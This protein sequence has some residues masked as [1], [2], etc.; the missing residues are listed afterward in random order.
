[1]CI[2]FVIKTFASDAPKKFHWLSFDNRNFMS[3][4]SNDW[5]VFCFPDTICDYGKIALFFKN[6]NRFLSTEHDCWS[7]IFKIA[8]HWDPIY[9]CVVNLMILSNRNWDSLLVIFFLLQIN[10]RCD[11]QFIANCKHLWLF[12]FI[13]FLFLFLDHSINIFC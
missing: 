5:P 3:F 13:I 8:S 7:T 1:M 2:T 6:W 9:G 12:S 4:Y 10:R 11:L